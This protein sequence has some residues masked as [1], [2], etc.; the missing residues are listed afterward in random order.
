M[1]KEIADCCRKLRLGQRIVE[2]YRTINAE[3]HEGFLLNLLKSELAHRETARKERGMKNA[4]FHNRKTFA[5]YSFDELKIP[6][7]ITENDLKACSFIKEQKNL[8]LYGNVGTGKTH[9]ATAIGIE[10]CKLGKNVR[11]YRTAALVNKLSE[12]RKNGKLNEFLKQLSS[13]DL[14]ICD[15]WGYVPLEREA[16]Q[17][18]FQV[19]SDCYEKRSVIITTNLEFSRWVSI[20]YDEQMTAAM[21]DRL[22]HHSYLFIFDGKSYRMKHSLIKNLH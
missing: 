11:F 3:T 19:I 9:L 17:L 16:A 7:G 14:L 2:T 1:N 12:Y 15:E 21:I 22:I 18:L 8:I 13:L 6:Q 10:A 4:E 5:D 20:F